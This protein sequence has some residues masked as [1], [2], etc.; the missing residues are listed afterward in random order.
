MRADVHHRCAGER[1]G[2]VA[3]DGGPVTFG[4]QGLDG[5]DRPARLWPGDRGPTEHVDRPTERSHGRISNGHG[6]RG[7]GR[8]VPP[9][10]GGQ[11]GC[12]RGVPV[13]ATDDVDGGPDRHGG[14]IRPGGRQR[15][16]NGG[17]RRSGRSPAMIGCRLP[18]L[19]RGIRRRGTAPE[20]HG[21]AVDR[22]TGGIV[23]RAVQLSHPCELSGGGVES[24]DTTRRR[25]RCRQ[26]T[27]DDQVGT[28]PR[29]HHT[30]A[31][32]CRQP[33]RQ[34]PGLDRRR[35]G[36]GWGRPTRRGRGRRRRAGT[37]GQDRA[38]RHH[39]HGPDRR[40]SPDRTGWW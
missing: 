30:A 40:A 27:Q 4:V 20:D 11:D 7:D 38:G 2:Q 18:G 5:V 34:Q 1:H 36:E 17:C 23:H 10:A 21:P 24:V 29:K 31:D 15:S 13:V 25:V 9:V 26:S 22:R 8:E 37:A 19:H 39:H 35:G 33:P 14:R 12:I 28:L 3:D 6:Q 32:G 16:D